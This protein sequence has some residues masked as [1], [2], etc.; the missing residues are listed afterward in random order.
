MQMEL[1]PEDIDNAVTLFD[2][3]RDGIITQK[4]FKDQLEV[5]KTFEQ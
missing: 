2:T 3:S 5:M 4:E 1:T